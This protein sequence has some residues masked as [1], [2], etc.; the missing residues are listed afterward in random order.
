MTIAS[1]TTHTFDAVADAAG[2]HPVV[3]AERR[4]QVQHRPAALVGEDRAG[5]GRLVHV[6]QHAL[7]RHDGPHGAVLRPDHH[8]AAAGGAAHEDDGGARDAFGSRRLFDALVH[9]VPVLQAD[10]EHAAEAA[11]SCTS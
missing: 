6:V 7:H 8:A 10:D 9:H 2:G 1:A 5:A 4:V 11:L 3:A